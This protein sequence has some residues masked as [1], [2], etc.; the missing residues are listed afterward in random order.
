MFISKSDGVL[1][2][3]AEEKNPFEIISHILLKIVLCLD[4]IVIETGH[5]ISLNS[6]Q[7]LSYQHTQYF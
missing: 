3:N 5:S 7:Q 6:L 1:K 2:V 4:I